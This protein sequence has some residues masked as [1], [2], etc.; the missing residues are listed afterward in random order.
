MAYEQWLI[1]DTFYVDPRIPEE[2]NHRDKAMEHQF[3]RIT[4]KFGISKPDKT[5]SPKQT[6]MF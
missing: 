1:D 6:K 3:K 5:I 2:G 4:K